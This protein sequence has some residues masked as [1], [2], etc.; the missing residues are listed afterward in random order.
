[1]PEGRFHL[2]FLTVEQNEDR[3]NTEQGDKKE[4]TE[5]HFGGI[6][7]PILFK[8]VVNVILVFSETPP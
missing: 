6:L 7:C 4:T 8:F 3:K 2:Y 1:M 5:T